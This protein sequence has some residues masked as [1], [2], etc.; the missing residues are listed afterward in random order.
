MQ[1]FIAFLLSIIAV[2]LQITWLSKLTILTV[3]PNLILAG[4][5][6]WAICPKEEKNYW[7]IWLPVLMFD[8]LAGQPFG[9]FTL[10][11]WL[12]FFS[13]ELLASLLFKQNDW[14]AIL[15]LTVIGLVFFE[16]YQFLLQQFFA[17]WH[18]SKP[19][20]FSAFYGYAVLP[21]KIFYNGLVVLLGLVI[22]KKSKL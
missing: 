11:L 4:I 2:A 5:L 7:W 20:E 9:L 22:F 18:L 14:P 13:V 16:F 21:V 8:L 12:M 15:L 1:F 19:P 10:S 6:A 17:L 3:A